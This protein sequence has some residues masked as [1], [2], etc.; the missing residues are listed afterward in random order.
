[1]TIQV[2]D[3]AW[4]P[5]KLYQNRTTRRRIIKTTSTENRER[6]LKAVRQKN[7]ITY[8]GKAINVTTD[9]STETLKGGRAWT[10]VIRALNENNFNP[11]ILHPAKLWFKIDGAIKVLNNKQKL[12]QYMAT[13]PQL[14]KT[15]QGI[16]NT[17]N[18]SEQNHGRTHSTK[19]QETT[20]QQSRE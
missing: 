2:Q 3:D 19:P 9:F 14:Q 20:K 10:E 5:N 13:K 11:R 4:A 15:L 17:E 12:Q 7:Q 6:I 16:L 18:E 1:M 8:K